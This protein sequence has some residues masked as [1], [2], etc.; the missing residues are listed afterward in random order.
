M[1]VTG[2]RD[3]TVQMSCGHSDVLAVTPANEQR[4]REHS[5]TV[6][7]FTCHHLEQALAALRR[8]D[9]EA[10]Y[11]PFCM[12]VQGA[13]ADGYIQPLIEALEVAQRGIRA[14]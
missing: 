13:V 7:C 1:S 5:L 4:A 6:P 3:V 14:A 12:F 11:E 9:H 10:A 2:E 8:G